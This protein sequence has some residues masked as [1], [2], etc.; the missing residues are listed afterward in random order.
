MSPDGWLASSRLTTSTA[1]RV[2]FHPCYS[3]EDFVE[4][5]R[6]RREVDGLSY[7]LRAGP[8]NAREGRRGVAPSHVSS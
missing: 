5:Y 3:Y 1:R 7:E 4:G 2:Q 8:L 6:P